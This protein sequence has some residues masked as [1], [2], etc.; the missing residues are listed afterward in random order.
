MSEYIQSLMGSNPNDPF[1]P[2]PPSM[3]E[4]LLRGLAGSLPPVGQMQ[5]R[6]TGLGRTVG[7]G[8]RLGGSLA[9][10]IGEEMSKRRQDPLG[11]VLPVAQDVI[12]GLRDVR[13]PGQTL[14]VGGP[15]PSTPPPSLFQARAPMEFPGEPP[16]LDIPGRKA[17]SIEEARQYLSPALSN[18]FTALQYAAPQTL[19]HAFPDAIKEQQRQLNEFALQKAP[20]EVTEAR[21]KQEEGV[22][23]KA[24]EDQFRAK[25][26]TYMAILDPTAKDYARQAATGLAKIAAESG[27]LGKTGLFGEFMNLA[28]AEIRLEIQKAQAAV[29][30]QH[31]K[32]VQGNIEDRTKKNMELKALNLQGLTI[33]RQITDIDRRIDTAGYQEGMEGMVKNLNKRRERLMA[34][35][36]EVQEKATALSGGASSN[37]A[38]MLQLQNMIGELLTQ[39]ETGY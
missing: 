38:D 34:D 4:I 10:I 8:L 1:A 25:A 19:Q 28:S 15:V 21:R 16:Q 3:T 2:T 17:A 6:N 22:A 23:E 7:T 36:A 5:V 24:R 11:R 29:L 18:K 9:G 30:A 13:L 12:T 31:R 33:Q 37:A 39:Q 14:D 32:T 27:V 20:I 26:R 35:L